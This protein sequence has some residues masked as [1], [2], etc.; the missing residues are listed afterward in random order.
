MAERTSIIEATLP[1]RAAPDMAEGYVTEGLYGETVEQ[2]N[3][4]GDWSEIRLSDGYCGFALTRGIAASSTET[5]HRVSAIRT[6]LYPDTDLKTPPIR[7]ISFASLITVKS[8]ARNGFVETGEGWL[9]ERHLAPKNETQPDHVETA[10]QFLGT[11]YLWGGR[12]AFG[13]D[14]SAL[15]QLSLQAAGLDCPRDSGPQ[16][17][18]LPAVD[19]PPRRGDIVFFPGHVG[20][21]IDNADLLH[22][23]ATHMAVTIDPLGAVA[24]WTRKQSGKGVTGIARI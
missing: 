17:Q 12:S 19:G 8:A 15:V 6:H 22:A 3:R 14:C 1:L 16:K 4:S 10:R 5:T 20:L 11:P 9:Y 23:N 2:L 13:L 24:S 21:M 18:C 7:A